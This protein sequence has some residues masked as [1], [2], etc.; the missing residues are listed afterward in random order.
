MKQLIL[1]L[2][3]G[4]FSYCY[5]WGDELGMFVSFMYIFITLAN[6]FYNWA[7]KKSEGEGSSNAQSK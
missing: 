7:I 2:A 4:F 1:V 3:T 5:S 6:T